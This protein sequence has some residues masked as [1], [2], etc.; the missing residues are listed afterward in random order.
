M[1]TPIHLVLV[2]P[3]IPHNTGAVGRLCVG[4]GCR[5]HLIRPLGFRLLP[6]TIRRA[7]LDYWEHLDVNVHDTWTDFLTQMPTSRLFFLSTHGTRSLYEC[8]FERNDI[9]VFGSE[10]SGFPEEIYE[11]YA[12]QLFQIP[13]PG[14]HARSI[15]LANAVSVAAYEAYRQIAVRNQLC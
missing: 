11:R 8:A 3:E 12:E 7:G 14:E 15:N 5:L 6:E 10:S 2:R 1:T 13:M 4:L 9:L